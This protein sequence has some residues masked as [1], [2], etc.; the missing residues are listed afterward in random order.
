MLA[1][2]LPADVD[3]IHTHYL[4]TPA[5]VA[6]YAALIRG[7]GWSFSAHAKDIWTTPEWELR[8]KLADA[9]WGVT[10]TRANLDYLRSLS[11][12][13]GK[14]PSR[15]S[16]AGFLALSAAAGAHGE[17][18]AAVHDRLGRPRGGEEGLCRPAARARACSATTATGA[19]S[20]PAAGRSA[21]RLKAAG[22]EARHRRPH[23]LAR[24]AGPRLHLRTAEARRPLRAPLA[25]RPLRRPRR[26]AERADG[27]AGLCACRCSRPMSPAFRSW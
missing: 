12:R 4:H 20:M 14:D 9:A 6:R 21:T 10:C 24:R 13:A 27:G 22:G 15:L 19:S 2:E 7:M 23:H 11:R 5:S 16:R 1:H 8:E 17:S 18:A 3:W 26:A 25:P